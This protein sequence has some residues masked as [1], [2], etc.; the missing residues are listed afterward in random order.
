MYENFFVLWI[1]LSLFCVK[2]EQEVNCV[3]F[4][5]LSYLQISNVPV[6]LEAR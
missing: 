1:L 3:Q 2:C 6:Y 4:N 5:Q